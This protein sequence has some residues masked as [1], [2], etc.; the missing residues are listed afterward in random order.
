MRTCEGRYHGTHDHSTIVSS[1][2]ASPGW[3]RSPYHSCDTTSC[4]HTYKYG[5]QM[6]PQQ[7]QLGSATHMLDN[8]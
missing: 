8:G 3:Y 7:M 6:A 1:D 4:M 5:Q 2:G